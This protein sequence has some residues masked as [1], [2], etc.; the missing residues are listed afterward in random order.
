MGTLENPSPTE[1]ALV[2]TDDATFVTPGVPTI[3]GRPELLHRL[4]TEAVLSSVTI[5]PHRVEGSGTLAYA[6]GM[7]TCMADHT[8]PMAMRF[9]MVWRK[10]ADGYGESHTS[11]SVPIRPVSNV[12]ADPDGASDG[13][14][15]GEL[16]QLAAELRGRA[17]I[18]AAEQTRRKRKA[19][20]ALED[21]INARLAVTAA[22]PSSRR[23]RRN[24]A[25]HR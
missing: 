11:S 18:L 3:H 16:E 8:T 6:Y 1:R 4:E 23:S 17:P 7:F 14:P 24:I 10:E 15:D 9:L 21:V 20:T 25:A 13:H 22:R 2:Y 12:A 5:T 19:R